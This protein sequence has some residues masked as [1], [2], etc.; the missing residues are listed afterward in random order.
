MK[1]YSLLLLLCIASCQRFSNTNSAQSMKSKQL[2]GADKD[3][4][5]CK[6]SAG[7]TWSVV[8]DSC[9][10]IFEMGTRFISYESTT[11]K[12]DA[13][14]SVFV[15]LSNDKL[16]AEVFFGPKEKSVVMDAIKVMEGETMPIL[17]EN[18]TEKVTIRYYKDYYQ[19]LY[20]DTIRYVQPYNTTNGLRELLLKR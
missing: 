6:G 13:S 20:N 19:L 14:N 10:R 1:I 15:V 7:Y 8:K 5:D 3:K 2:V 18:K 16:K 12:E 11:G 9:I 17:F 4:H